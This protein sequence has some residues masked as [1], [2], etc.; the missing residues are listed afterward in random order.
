MFNAQIAFDKHA[1]GAGDHDGHVVVFKGFVRFLHDLCDGI[2]YIRK[3]PAVNAVNHFI[4][5]V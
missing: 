5:I 1:A 2:F 4:R 3:M